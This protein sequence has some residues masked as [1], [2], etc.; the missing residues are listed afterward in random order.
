MSLSRPTIT[1]NAW[2]KKAEEEIMRDVAAVAAR[3]R[4]ETIGHVL[5]PGAFIPGPPGTGKSV[6][7]DHIVK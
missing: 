6:F 1:L 3:K 4:G 7:I 5:R 2:Q